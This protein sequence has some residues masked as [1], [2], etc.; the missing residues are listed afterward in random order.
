MKRTPLK[1][2]T[3]LNRGKS[4]LKKSS[5][6]KRSK[7]TE[8]KYVE[9]R[10]L[11]EKILTETPKCEAC[12]IYNSYDGVRWRV[13]KSEHLH[14]I[15][16]RSQ[17][18]DILDESIIVAVCPVC[19]ARVDEDRIVSELLGLYM[20]SYHYTKEN[21]KEA[22]RVRESWKAGKP[23]IASYITEIVKD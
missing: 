12:E 2:K 23:T 7:K 16:L 21:V 17:G 3:P 13:N 11:V 6:R 10:A 14:E 20:R 18:G 5:L 4:E 19:H 22:K 8:E 9:R 15:V 1:R